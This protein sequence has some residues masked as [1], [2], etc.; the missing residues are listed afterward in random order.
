MPP[1]RSAVRNRQILYKVINLVWSARVSERKEN[2]P[3]VMAGLM[4]RALA[5]AS[6]CHSM[7]SAPI[8][9]PGM[10]DGAEKA[11]RNAS[12][13]LGAPRF[14]D[15]RTSRTV[16][17]RGRGKGAVGRLFKVKVSETQPKI[18]P[19]PDLFGSKTQ[20]PPKVAFLNLRAIQRSV[21][22]RSAIRDGTI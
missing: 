19:I 20:K 1:E 11:C 7:P 21:S 17:G 22:Q 8:R 9:H 14:G 3:D 10:S 2:I 5:K 12:G 4:E 15:D 6:G 18:T 16:R 13:R